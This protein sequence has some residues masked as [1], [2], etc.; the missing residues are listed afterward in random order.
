MPGTAAGGHPADVEVLDGDHG[1][2][3]GELTGELVQPLG[4]LVTYPAIYSG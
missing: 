2:G 3:V 4:P 1:A